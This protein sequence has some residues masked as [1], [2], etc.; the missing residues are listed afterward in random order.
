MIN[1][2][3]TPSPVV[4]LNLLEEPARFDEDHRLEAA[5]EQRLAPFGVTT[6]HSYRFLVLDTP[7]GLVRNQSVYERL[8]RFR[9][10]TR[11]SVLCLLVGDLPPEAGG[12]GESPALHRP[13][14]LRTASVGL[15][16]AADLKAGGPRGPSAR[17][18]TPDPQALRT[19]AGL[20][21]GPELFDRVLQRLTAS[22]NGVAAPGLRLLEYDLSPAARDQAWGNAAARFV[23][24]PSYGSTSGPHGKGGAASL[25][26]PL[27]RLAGGKGSGP[28][29]EYARG[30]PLEA[31]RERCVEALRTAGRAR[32]VLATQGGL[33]S[34]RGSDGFTM[35]LDGAR[36]ALGDYLAQVNGVVD[37]GAQPP[38][39]VEVRE[40]VLRLKELGL[41]LPPSGVT[42]ERA[43][44][45]LCALA[46]QLFDDGLTL[47]AV[48]DR[49]EDCSARMMPHQEDAL[50]EA[51]GRACPQALLAPGGGGVPP[52]VGSL[53]GTRALTFL[54]GALAGLGAWPWGAG[55]AAV[56]LLVLY[57]G[58]LTSRH[59]PGDAP[60][61]RAAFGGRYV[62]AQGTLVL[63]GGA[64]GA[65]LGT[66]L[67]LPGWTAS[68]ALPAGLLLAWTAVVRAWDRAVAQIWKDSGAAAVQAAVR[69]LDE[70]LDRAVR[71]RW[72]AETE[73]IDCAEAA[74]SVSVVLN[75][76][77]DLITATADAGVR[78]EEQHPDP[79]PDADDPLADDR[80]P[81][82]GDAPEL[83]VPSWMARTGPAG[84]PLR[85][86]TPTGHPGPAA[87]DRPPPWLDRQSGEGGPDLVP[88]L[89]G[90]FAEL[91]RQ[92][93]A[94]HWD[95][96]RGG[97]AA[98]GSERQV[99]RKARELLEVAQ[100]HLLRNGVVPAPPFAAPARARSGPA[101]LLGLGLDRVVEA[102]GPNAVQK[103]VV[104]LVSTRQLPL[105]SRDPAAVEWIRFAPLA[106]RAQLDGR[107]TDGDGGAVWTSSGRHAGRLRLTPLRSGSVR[108]VMAYHDPDPGRDTHP[109]HPVAAPEPQVATPA[110]PAAEREQPSSGSDP[111]AEEHTW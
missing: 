84:R 58:F 5:V 40:M 50:A 42:P 20:L 73:R 82:P 95:A 89:S 108:T 15:I 101:G 109:E 30:G 37:L 22:C 46:E 26:E 32:K 96:L 28:A 16:W 49:F 47:R 11:I 36:S 59:L 102:A 52:A 33:V 69:A 65:A 53:L 103:E 4:Q 66:V 79:D 55:T 56:A 63:L 74:R 93:L 81:G 80:W 57:G 99:A 70:V 85:A 25:P 107:G 18:G 13:A 14:L 45:G 83:D 77:A 86:R 90:D 2:Q 8:L 19:L 104:P 105:L 110:A 27:D 64:A 61:A 24:Q 92:S 94:P 7:E 87:D 91:V 43:G 9:R 17:T 51:P 12:G 48:A 6:P 21:L 44:E 38:G 34:G 98:S 72:W 31:V 76:L 23:G 75:T 111:S 10:A 1:D 3:E 106:V 54:A 60:R 35:A 100:R 39:V 67:G 71:Q 68:I 29:G 78:D 88:T 97:H 41:D 62:G